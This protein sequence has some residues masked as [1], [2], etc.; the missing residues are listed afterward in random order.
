MKTNYELTLDRTPEGNIIC[1]VMRPPI[2]IHTF[3]AEPMGKEYK[4]YELVSRGERIDIGSVE[5]ESTA[6][7]NLSRLAQQFI[8]GYTPVRRKIR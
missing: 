8:L 7:L 2:C 6:R 3:T 4:L 5:G 1:N